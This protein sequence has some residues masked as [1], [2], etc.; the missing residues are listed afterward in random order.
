MELTIQLFKPDMSNIINL[1]IQLLF[2]LKYKSKNYINKTLNFQSTFIFINSF[3]SLSFFCHITIK[4][5]IF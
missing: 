2:I 1:R 4:R 5:E 3:F